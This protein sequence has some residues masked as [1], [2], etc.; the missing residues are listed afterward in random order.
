MTL[1]SVLIRNTSITMGAGVRE[2]GGLRGPMFRVATIF[3][4]LLLAMG[5]TSQSNAKKV[6]IIGIQAEPVS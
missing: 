6:C 2:S 5:W 1:S 3:A 4:A